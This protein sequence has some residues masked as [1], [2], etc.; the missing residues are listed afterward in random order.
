MQIVPRLIRANDLPALAEKMQIKENRNKVQNWGR[1]HLPEKEKST[2]ATWQLQ[3]G[4]IA[5]GIQ[6]ERNPDAWLPVP[7]MPLLGQCGTEE[8]GTDNASVLLP[9]PPLFKEWDL[10]ID[11][12]SCS[13]KHSG[14][15]LF[16]LAGLLKKNAFFG[17]KDILTGLLKKSGYAL[18]WL[19][20]GERSAHLDLN[21]S[22]S[23]REDFVWN[24]YCHLLYLGDD[25]RP[26]GIYSSCKY[27]HEESPH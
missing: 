23:N 19:V 15:M 11:I 10:E 24:D 21:N 27:L 16:G 12:P 22:G 14:A 6:V 9:L 26:N 4:S 5:Q 1:L 13:I 20:R 18:V 2:I 7:S 8:E 25:G 17:R 3:E